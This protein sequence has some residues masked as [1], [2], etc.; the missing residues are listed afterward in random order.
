MSEAAAFAATFTDFRLIKGRKVCQVHLELPIERAEEFV[1]AF[2]IPDPS[3]ETWVGIARLNA[4]PEKSVIEPGKPT[5]A[6]KRRWEDLL[7][8][9]QAGIACSDPQFRR[10]LKEETSWQFLDGQPEDEEAAKAIRIY[11]GVSSRSE[12]KPGS[13]SAAKWRQLYD[14]YTLWRDY[15]EHRA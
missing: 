15:P 6:Q 3:K 1:R 10:W 13:P 8:A 2:G 5:Q 7:P 11:C 14:S 9:Q 12:L 4:E